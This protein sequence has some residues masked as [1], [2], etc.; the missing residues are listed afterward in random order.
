MNST[1]KQSIEETHRR[2]NRACG[3]MVHLRNK[4]LSLLRMYEKAASEGIH[5]L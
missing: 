3:Q 2:F 1:T 5:I 4:K